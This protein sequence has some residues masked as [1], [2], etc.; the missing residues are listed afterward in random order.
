MEELKTDEKLSSQ[1]YWDQVLEKAQLPRVNTPA[2]YH[3]SVTM[4]YVDAEIRRKKYSTFFEVG[5]GSSGWLPYFAHTYGLTVSGIDYSE[6][7]C[8]LAEENLRILNIP[9]DEIICK[10]LFEKNCTGGRTYDIVFSYGVIEHFDHPEDIIRI[11]SSFLNP[12]GLMIT[13]VPNLNGLMGR[14]SRRYIPDIY[15]I[16]K[17]MTREQL[18]QFHE[19]NS[20]KTLKA[21]YAG[22]FTLAVMPLVHSKHWLLRQDTRLG[23]TGMALFSLID[24]VCSKLFRLFRINLPSKAFSPYIICVAEKGQPS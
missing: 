12:G 16:H 18:R 7:G 14:M 8:R 23:R 21:G 13:L 11:F 17:V 24:K 3:Y 19:V 10:D 1:L 22:T 2:S 20:L 15:K 4:S 6:V 9:H 5:C